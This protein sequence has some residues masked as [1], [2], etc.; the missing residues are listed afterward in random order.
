MNI[1]KKAFLLFIGSTFLISAFAQQSKSNIYDTHGWLLSS[2]IYELPQK[3]NV[4]VDYIARFNNHISNYYGSY[5]VLGVT[6]KVKPNVDL[7]AAYRI[8]FANRSVLYRLTLGAELFKKRKKIV[9]S[10][11]FQLQNQIQDFDMPTTTNVNSNSVYLLS[12]SKLKYLLSKKINLFASVEPIFKIG[13]NHLFD[14]FLS[15]AGL[16]ILPND[17]TRINLFFLNRTYFSHPDYKIISKIL[18]ASVYFK[19][20]HLKR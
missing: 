6:K 8:G 3:W 10:N 5:Y 16:D 4:N 18:S 12:K 2:F 11:R 9:F 15:T 20:N 1:R 19:L 17:N 13:K 7:M 14:Q